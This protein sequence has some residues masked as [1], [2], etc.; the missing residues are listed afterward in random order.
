MKSEKDSNKTQRR[1]TKDISWKLSP[2]SP[3]P[4]LFPPHPQSSMDKKKPF[5]AAVRK[6]SLYKTCNALYHQHRKSDSQQAVVLFHSWSHTTQRLHWRKLVSEAKGTY[7]IHYF[8]SSDRLST[9]CTH[10]TFSPRKI[11]FRTLGVFL[12]VPQ[13]GPCLRYT[14]MLLSC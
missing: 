12:P 5:A 6:V 11:E 9:C 8:T 10:C 14:G 2:P 13:P 4:P 1:Q 7:I 3:I